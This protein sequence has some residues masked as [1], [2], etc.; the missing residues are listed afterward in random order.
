LQL[1]ETAT[2]KEQHQQY[3]EHK[4]DQ[5]RRNKDERMVLRVYPQATQQRNGQEE[6]GQHN[7]AHQRAIS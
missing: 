3:C 5:R 4:S 7:G 6:H 2:N 1:Y